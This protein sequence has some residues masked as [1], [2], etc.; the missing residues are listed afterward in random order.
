MVKRLIVICCLVTACATPVDLP[1]EVKDADG[2]GGAT[3]KVEFVKWVG[4]LILTT[5]GVFNIKIEVKN[6]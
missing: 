5:I 4:Q 1:D 6:D 2:I 3:A